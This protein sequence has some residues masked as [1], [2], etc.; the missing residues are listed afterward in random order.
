LTGRDE[1]GEWLREHFEVGD[2]AFINLMS[3]RAPFWD[4]LA[5]AIGAGP[6]ILRDGEFHQDPHAL[7][8]EGEEFT[9]DWK[10]SHYDLRQP[11]TFAGTNADGT[12]LVL[13]VA[14]GRQAEFSRGVMQREE[15]EVL[16]EFGCTMGMDFDSGGSSTMVIG[17]EVVNH[18]SDR[19]RP[20]GTGGVERE[21]AN[22]LLIFS[23][24]PD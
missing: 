12:L 4:H 3:S 24:S 19:A 10:H 1:A 8:P 18:V 17:G 5:Q 7:F 21:V 6:C 23:E 13:G 16:L 9:L 15:A 2:R 22:A 20:D 11:R 14:D